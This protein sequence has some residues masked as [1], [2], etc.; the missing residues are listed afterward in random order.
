MA[1]IIS[2]EPCGAEEES[3]GDEAD[4]PLFDRQDDPVS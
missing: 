3:S 1:I 2:I 4:P